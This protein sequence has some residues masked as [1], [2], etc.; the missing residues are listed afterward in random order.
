MK[1]LRL[2]IKMMT[3]K[4]AASLLSVSQLTILRAIKNG[5]L[6]AMQMSPKGR[7]KI[8]IDHLNSFIRIHTK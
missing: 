7:Y 5:K 8:S 4:E 6:K 1:S 3:V 2:Q